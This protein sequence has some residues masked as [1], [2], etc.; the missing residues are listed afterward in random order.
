MDN[1]SLHESLQD[2][3]VC[4]L[5]KPFLTHW[6]EGVKRFV[7]Q[8]EPGAGKSTGIPLFLLYGEPGLGKILMLEPRRM[9]ARSLAG[10][11][12]SLMGESPGGQVG[13]RVRGE[14]RCSNRTRLEIVTEGVFIRMIQENPELPGIDAVILDE[15]HERN[16][17][18]DLSYALLMDVQE[19]L[20][21][22]LGIIIM[23]AT[24]EKELLEER[25]SRS[26]YLESHG[27]MFP[28]DLFYRKPKEGFRIDPSCIADA[29]RQGLE[30]RDG[31]VLVFLPGE[32]E[33]HRMEQ[34]LKETIGNTECSIVPL[35][36]RLSF[37]EQEKVFETG[38][39]RKVILATSIAETSL[40]IPGITTVVDT[41]LERKPVFNRHSGLTKLET[42]PISRASSEQRA[43]RAGRVRE[44][45]CLRLWSEADQAGLDGFR[46]PEILTTDLSSLVLEILY[47]GAKQPEDLCWLE[48]PPRS[49]FFQAVE[50]LRMLE[51][52][53]K[54]GQLSTVGKE[55]VTMGL[56]PR[57]ARL[58]VE[59]RK[60]GLDE[61]ACC[62]AA[63]L[64][65]RDWMGRGTDS[66]I[67]A[68]LEALKNRRDSNS[69]IVKRILKLWKSLLKRKP[70]PMKIRPEAAAELLMLAYPDRI[71]KKLADCT[72]HLSGGGNALLLQT[73]SLQTREFLIV[74]ETGGA[75]REA[76]IFL[77]CPVT[78]DEV[79]DQCRGI[80]RESERIRWDEE[81]NRL[82]SRMQITLG[83]IVLKEVPHPKPSAEAIAREL[84]VL[85]TKK[86]LGILPWSREDREYWNRCRF[87]R[88]GEW[89]DFSEEGLLLRLEEWFLPLLIKG[90][91]ESPLKEGLRS[92]L[93][94]GQQS[95]LDH[96]VPEKIQVP[97]GS[98]LRIDYSDPG[99]P[100]LDVKIQE[101]FGLNETPLIAGKI[102]LVM[103]LLNP[104]RRPIQ[105]TRD[106]KSFWENTYPEVR[107]ELRGRY[108]KH[109]WPENPFEAVPTSRVRPR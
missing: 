94:W 25:F 18:S 92:L 8:A 87:I 84:G 56:H 43:G 74:A 49:H 22:D 90:K 26:C 79:L 42:R 53:K 67:H 2:L 91:L 95:Y 5:F 4:K 69:P 21:E 51:A 70:E 14:S 76:K 17:F 39:A 62:L 23:S 46:A 37:R 50:L 75:G 104:A 40:T 54:D 36:G 82:H 52:V 15:F 10:Y 6:Q 86:G 83:Q 48:E 3:P 72:Y 103:R 13:Y 55:M 88:E 80:L 60:R 105:V 59:G 38:A 98:R 89:P 41:G 77:S 9:A 85:F 31:D 16:L 24:P 61:T 107:K 63:F 34:Y 96:H 20:R 1:F 108:P 12:S 78:R 106:L 65:E 57:L 19:N 11:L 28:V 30:D 47:W 97:S 99:Q 73:D 68:R 101:L 102:P 32:G 7:I 44:G 64:S 71:G 27:R 33:I 93:N 100:A 35:Y 45:L 109:Y 29:V 81:K 58:V 66:D